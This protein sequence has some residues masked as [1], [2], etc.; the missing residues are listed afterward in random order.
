MKARRYLAIGAAALAGLAALLAGL[1]LLAFE[2]NRYKPE[3]IRIVQEK[4]GRMLTIDGRIGLT[5]FPHLGVVVDTLALSGPGG[6]GKFASVGEA[7]LAVA[8][9]P[10]LANR[11]VI[12]SVDLSDVDVD[13]V[14][15]HDGTTNFDDFVAGSE[16]RTPDATSG[17]S[18]IAVVPPALE[19]GGIGGFRVRQA[20]I[21][22]RDEADGRSLRLTGLD[23][24]TDRPGEGA[25]G[26]WTLA[27]RVESSRPAVKAE[28]KGSGRY[29]LEFSER[30]F[31]L[32]HIDLQVTGDAPGVPGLVATLKGN[33]ALDPAH[34]RLTIAQ[35]A[36]TAT[37][38]DGVDL[39]AS[40][41][42]LRLA[43]SGAAGGAARVEVK[44]ARPAGTLTAKI[45]CSELAATAQQIRFEK[46]GVDAEMG[47]GTTRLVAKL[48]SPLAIDGAAQTIALPSLAGDLL[49][50]GPQLPNGSAKGSLSG[51]ADVAW[52]K[53]SGARAN[54]VA[55]IDDANLGVKLVVANLDRPAVQFDVTVDRLDLERYFP[56]LPMP[57]GDASPGDGK[58]GTAAPPGGGPPDTPAQP[59]DLS[60]LR[61]LT[62]SGSVR[63][64]ALAARRIKAQNLLVRVRASGGQ[65]EISSLNAK[66]YQGTL[67]GDASIDTN[68]NRFS[69]G[70]QLT[71]VAL[72]PL[73]R[74]AAGFERIEGRGNVALR[75]T[76][77][78]TTLVAM[79]RALAGRARI[80]IHDGA[81]KGVNLGEIVKVA[82]SLLGSN[83]AIEGKAQASDQTKFSDLS[84]TY[85]IR[86][87]IAHNDDLAGR[88]PL[89]K[90]TGAGSIDIGAQ[91]VDYLVKATPVG[92]IPIGGGRTLTV[93]QGVADGLQAESV[94][95]S[96]SAPEVCTTPPAASVEPWP[97]AAARKHCAEACR[98]GRR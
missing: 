74:A 51:A 6:T 81:V 16:A 58:P 71:G 7:K 31:A 69:L 42:D 50:S 77:T 94:S 9:L 55:K 22:W 26:Q 97:L 25:R 70:A 45:A 44:L 40:V 23:A 83:S 53:P 66:L 95:R 3:I 43:P 8:L 32:D 64:A 56:L 37:T 88:S 2:P 18:P 91:R 30:V 65:I 11:L 62:A 38:T 89:L 24:Q 49:A 87:G 84:A 46:F 92:A 67:V 39:Q 17:P 80:D 20:N 15:R 61:T 63:I 93:L 19:I 14:K 28:L 72:G 68:N 82:G 79:Q 57:T 27:T 54:L 13:L 96:R 86:N 48:V 78:G 5:F 4:T 35:L 21:A 60:A 34:A 10:L 75:I 90:V 33:I 47:W 59:I 85:V 36:I 12:E 76:T 98:L 73:L 1:I 29:H 52:G 41:P